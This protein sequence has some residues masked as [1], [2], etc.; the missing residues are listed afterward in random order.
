MWLCR[1]RNGVGNIK[2]LLTPKIAFYCIT[3]RA[4]RRYD[5][6]PVLPCTLYDSYPDSVY[7][8]Y[9]FMS[10]YLAGQ[11]FYLFCL[12]AE[13]AA[14][15]ADDLIY[16]LGHRVGDAGEKLL[17]LALLADNILEVLLHLLDLFLKRSGV[18]FF[19]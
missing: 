9:C 15:K 14:Y 7:C 6:T 16:K 8:C 1:H 2:P 18:K 11:I 4:Y 17:Y 5:D 19:H 12:S 10:S 13:Y 3:K